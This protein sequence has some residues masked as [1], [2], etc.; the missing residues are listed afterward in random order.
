MRF[1]TVMEN[2]ACR[3]DLCAGHGPSLYIE[4]PKHKIL[5][6]MGPSAAFA[7]NA[8]ALGVDLAGV[9]VAFLSHGHSDHSGGLMAFL[10]KNDAAPVYLHKAAFGRYWSNF[11]EAPRYIGLDPELSRYEHRFVKTEGVVQIRFLTGHFE[12]D[13]G[14]Q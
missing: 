6:D 8:A 2:T 3:E 10:E 9:D 14:D 12:A 11:G 4:T 7:D 13:E 5:F 1:V